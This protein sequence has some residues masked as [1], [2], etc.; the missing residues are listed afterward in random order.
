[1]TT[2]IDDP[3]THAPEDLSNEA[4][5]NHLAEPPLEHSEYGG[6]TMALPPPRPKNDFSALRDLSLDHPDSGFHIAP[7]SLNTDEYAADTD[8]QQFKGNAVR[9]ENAV[10]DPTKILRQGILTPSPQTI[11][12]FQ[13][14]RKTPLA[15][16]DCGSGILSMS[17]IFIQ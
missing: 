3:N 1:M 14:K 4:C 12:R 10:F 17:F 16:G 8:I 5:V 2:R 7:L 9:L 15:M 11:T 13:T 6:A